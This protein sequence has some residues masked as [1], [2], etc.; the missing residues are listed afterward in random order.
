MNSVSKQLRNSGVKS[1][2]KILV[3]IILKIKKKWMR[4]NE[5][6]SYFVES[7]VKGRKNRTK[8]FRW[9]TMLS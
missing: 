1:T 7:T 8:D 6:L 2:R 5:I 4:G 9:L 3:D